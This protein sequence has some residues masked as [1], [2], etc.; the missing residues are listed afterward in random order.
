M[1]EEEYTYGDTPLI[2][3]DMVGKE[4]SETLKKQIKIK[5]SQVHNIRNNV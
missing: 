5:T 4:V 3:K 1:S 2:I